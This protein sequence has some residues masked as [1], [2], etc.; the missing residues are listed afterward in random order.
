LILT[1]KLP[2]INAILNLAIALSA[3][4]TRVVIKAVHIWA[5][6][7]FFVVPMKDLM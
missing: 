7:A 5:I 4:S 1:N 6:T 3:F 2:L